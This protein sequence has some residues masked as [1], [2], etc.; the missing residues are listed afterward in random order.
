LSIKLY[1]AIIIVLVVL[2]LLTMP[3]RRRRGETADDRRRARLH[4]SRLVHH[5]GFEVSDTGHK[6]KR[7]VHAK[8]RRG[9]HECSNECPYCARGQEY[10]ATQLRVF[11]D[12]PIRGRKDRRAMREER[13]GSR[14]D[15]PWREED[16]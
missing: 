2:W 8:E 1:I 5:A 15:R 14:R 3:A 11:D 16:D 4:N 13:G 6:G 9:A 10:Q 7:R 12:R